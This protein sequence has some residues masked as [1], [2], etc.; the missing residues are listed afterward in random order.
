MLDA[1]RMDAG[2]R[3]QLGWALLEGKEDPERADE[4][5]QAT[6]R[7]ALELDL[8]RIRRSIPCTR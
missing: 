4:N 2:E 6:V 5:A 8:R 7:C 3:G 1:P